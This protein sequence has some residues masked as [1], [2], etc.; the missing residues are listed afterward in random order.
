MKIESYRPISVEEVA[1]A[2]QDSQWVTDLLVPVHEQIR[3]LTLALQKNV[4]VDNLAVESRTVS[5]R[6]G[7]K[8]TLDLQVVQGRPLGAVILASNSAVLSLFVEPTD[9][10][11]ISLTATFTETSSDV[12]VKVLIF[13]A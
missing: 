1:N 5:M 6:S 3:A 11:K 4:S 9:I 8:T 2:P 7:R 10:K 12:E 13:G